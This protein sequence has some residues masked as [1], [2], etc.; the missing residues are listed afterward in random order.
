MNLNLKPSEISKITESELIHIKYD[1]KIRTFVTDS[2][3]VKKGDVFWALKG[4]NF[5]GNDF[6]DDAIKKGSVGII[7]SKKSK[8]YSKCDFYIYSKD[9]LSALH[10]LAEYHLSRFSIPVISV[11]GSNGKTTTKEMIKEVLS[12]F[13]PTVSNK[14]NFNNEYG[15]PLSVLETEKKHRFAVF[16]IGTSSPGEIKKLSA[17]VKPDV[18]VI[19]TIAKEHMEFFK[20]IE[21]VYREETSVIENMK[22]N[23]YVIINGDNLYLKRLKKLKNVISFG[24]NKENDLIIKRGKDHYF[25]IYKDQKYPVKLKNNIEHNYLNAASAFITGKIFSLPSDKIIKAL[26]EFE[27]VALRMQIIKRKNSLIILDAYN[28]NPQSMEYALREIS[29]RKP[30]S[31]I[32]GDMKELGSDSK[33][34]HIRIAK[35]IERLK[36]DNIYLIG[37]EMMNAY[38]Y[39]K[40]RVKNIKYYITTEDAFD[41]VKGFIKREKNQNIL[42]KASRSMK[43]ERFLDIDYH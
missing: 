12:Y 1:K 19:T 9:T 41:E 26:E 36:P 16:E 43:F 27:G 38:E 37:H 21:N 25:F 2:R 28:A 40:K 34:E 13:A 29:K 8:I 30:F 24:F 35:L 11:T 4:K 39:L 20:N 6:V 22:T 7:S 42:I 32:L 3:T 10:R 15:L 5:D 31:V 23:G 14:G 17:I 33:K 18:A